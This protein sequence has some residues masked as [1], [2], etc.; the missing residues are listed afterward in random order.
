MLVFLWKP[1]PLRTGLWKPDVFYRY[2]V[3]DYLLVFHIQIHAVSDVATT[4]CTGKIVA[5]CAVSFE[6]PGYRVV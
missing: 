4:A 6:F 3:K 1:R 2:S 5:A